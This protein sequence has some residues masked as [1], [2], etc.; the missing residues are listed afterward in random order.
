[1]LPRCVQIKIILIFVSNVTF[2]LKRNN[3]GKTGLGVLNLI[4]LKRVSLGA[5]REECKSS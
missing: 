1:M 5:W 4:K 3:R 2:G